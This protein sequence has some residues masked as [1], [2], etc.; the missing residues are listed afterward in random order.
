MTTLHPAH[1]HPPNPRTIPTFA[2]ISGAQVQ[3][4]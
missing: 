1:T 3:H 4:V 2:V